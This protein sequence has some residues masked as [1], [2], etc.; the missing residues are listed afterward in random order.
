VKVWGRRIQA[1]EACLIGFS[2]A[3]LPVG[4][5]LRMVLEGNAP[6]TLSP[7][8]QSLFPRALASAAHISTNVDA[9]VETRD[10]LE[11]FDN[12]NPMTLNLDY[13]MKTWETLDW[14]PTLNLAPQYN[15]LANLRIVNAKTDGEELNN[16]LFAHVGTL[17]AVELKDICLLWPGSADF[18]WKSIVLTLSRM[19]ELQYLYLTTLLAFPLG[20]VVP[21]K[22]DVRA[23]QEVGW[24]SK[25]H[26]TYALRVLCDYYRLGGAS[27][28][29]VNMFHVEEKLMEDYGIT[30]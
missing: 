27:D 1:F 19:M 4:V 7:K 14:T 30:I 2:E 18:P 12:I 28:N 22:I 17:R 26:V 23:F 8:A 13:E 15:R 5:E 11:W 9:Y 6:R 24:K 3:K 25:E 21:K 20:H 29:F 16:F 10:N